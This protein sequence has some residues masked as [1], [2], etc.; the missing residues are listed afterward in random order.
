M[1]FFSTQVRLGR[2]AAPANSTWRAVAYLGSFVILENIGLE[3]REKE[4]HRV[5]GVSLEGELR[6]NRR[7]MH[8]CSTFYL[9][10]LIRVPQK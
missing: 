4:T 2:Q 8:V 6:E 3:E 1:S 9:Q 10:A 7:L 5:G